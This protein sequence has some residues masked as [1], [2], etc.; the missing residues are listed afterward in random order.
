MFR[1]SEPVRNG[2]FLAELALSCK[3]FK[4]I[5]HPYQE[6]I[7]Q[8]QVNKVRKDKGLFCA[9]LSWL[10]TPPLPDTPLKLDTM[11]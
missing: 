11:S 9:Y 8:M 10:S 6:E 2:R 4:E 1:Q 7:P 3:I 5:I